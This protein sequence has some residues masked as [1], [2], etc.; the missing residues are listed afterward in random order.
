[1]KNVLIDSV[2]N[3][4]LKKTDYT[5]SLDNN[6]VIIKKRTETGD[7]N[8]AMEQN[9]KVITGTVCDKE[10]VTLPGVS[11]YIKGTTVGVVTD[12]DGAYKLEV[13]A[14]AQKL[15]FSFVGMETRE[16]ELGK[17]TTVNVVMKENVS[18]L[19]EVTVIAY[20]ERN[21][22]ELISSCLLYTSKPY[23]FSGG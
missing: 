16:V 18:D 17:E 2:M 8:A 14:N 10:K 12:V 15:V 1:M 5:Y 6:I 19:D 22:K 21:K 7:K 13:P 3:I 23:D 11:V 9:R 4:C 20:G